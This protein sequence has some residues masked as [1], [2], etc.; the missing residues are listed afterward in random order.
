M[1][2]REQSIIAIQSRL[3]VITQ[4]Y[5]QLICTRATNIPAHSTIPIYSILYVWQPLQKLW[6]YFQ[7][8]DKGC[9]IIRRAEFTGHYSTFLELYWMYFLLFSACA[10]I[11]IGRK[12]ALNSELCLTSMHVLLQTYLRSMANYLITQSF[13]HIEC[14]Y[15]PTSSAS[16]W[17]SLLKKPELK[18]AIVISTSSKRLEPWA[19]KQPYSY[20]GQ[21]SHNM[22]FYT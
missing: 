20:Q 2:H 17:C 7:S 22:H 1:W 3:P 11:S 6:D 4:S 18:I 12:S 5:S 21:G 14:W 19:S 13:V 15:I 16:K 9:W 8:F 10:C